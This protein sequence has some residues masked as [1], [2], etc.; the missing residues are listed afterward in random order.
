MINETFMRLDDW[1]LRLDPDTPLS[2]RRECRKYDQI[3]ITESRIDGDLTR[4]TLCQSALFRGP[5]LKRS[6]QMTT[7]GGA[8]MEWFLGN[9]A[10]AG[11]NVQWIFVA[12]RVWANWVSRITAD[13]AWAGMTRPAGIDIPATK[14]PDSTSTD[15]GFDFKSVGTRELLQ[16]I[17]PRI[18]VEWDIKPSGAIQFVGAGSGNY[19]QGGSG[20]TPLVVV[21]R[22]LEGRDIAL[23]G[24]EVVDIDREEDASRNASEVTVWDGPGFLYFGYL[25]SAG[26]AERFTYDVTGQRL[27]HRASIQNSALTSLADGDRLAAEAYAETAPANNY[28]A[29]VREWYP[30]RFLKPGDYVWAFDDACEI[31]AATETGI[32][33]RGEFVAADVLRCYGIRWAFR[34]GMGCYRL[35][36]G[37]PASYETTRTEVLDIT[38]YVLPEDGDCEL[39]IGSPEQSIADILGTS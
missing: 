15:D 4:T 7:L 38:D 31:S 12:D 20:S 1:S 36:R 11:P 5:I 24:L 26:N 3:V 13:N 35:T 30:G 9:A 32:L 22:G 37:D 29:I 14:Y 23:I 33:Y 6:D 25:G 8:G 2:V 10:G 17:A 21:M 34:E 39:I 18:G 27:D 16:R 19:W 28:R